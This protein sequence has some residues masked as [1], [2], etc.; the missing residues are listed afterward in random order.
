MA[1]LRPLSTSTTRARRGTSTSTAPTSARPAPGTTTTPRPPS[2]RGTGS[3]R[4][5]E[6]GAELGG[7][8]VKDRLWVWGAYS[9]QQIDLFTINDFSDKTTLKDWNGKL[10]AQIT[11]ANSATAFAFNGD[12]IKTGRNAGPLRPQETTWDQSNFGPSPTGYKAEDTQILGTDFYLTGMYSVVNGGFQ[13]AP[14]GGS[15]LAYRDPSQVWHNSFFLNQLERP[16]KQGKLDASNFFNIGGFS[17]ELKYGAGYRTAEQSSL[18]SW[19]GGGLDLAAGGGHPPPVPR[20]RRPTPRS[21]T[22]YGSAYLQD[23]LSRGNLTANVG[24]RYDRQGGKNLAST[25][26][27]NSG[28]SRISCRRS[29]TRARTPASPGPRSPRASG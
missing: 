1:R 6:L 24:L 4:T 28:A 21:K 18:F 13:L 26:A 25:A 22:D 9:R 3:T 2:S 5:E 23:T 17:N 16:Q 20:P 29:T 14:E 10:N 15:A 27:A 7:P 12:K 19:P 11:P 8:I